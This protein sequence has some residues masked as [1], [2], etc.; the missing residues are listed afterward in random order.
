MSQKSAITYGKRSLAEDRCIF[1]MISLISISLMWRMT[2]KK[3]KAENHDSFYNRYKSFQK[4][5]SK[6]KQ[7]KECFCI[8][9][10]SNKFTKQKNIKK[11]KICY[12]STGILCYIYLELDILPDSPFPL[13]MCFASISYGFSYVQKLWRNNREVNCLLLF[14]Q[15]S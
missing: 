1:S 8:M 12:L 7:Q 10:F 15:P 2:L 5:A 3:F 4:Q 13:C 11:R 9:R 6:Q 14:M